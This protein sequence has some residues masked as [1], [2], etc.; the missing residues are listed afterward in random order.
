MSDHV[1]GAN[2]LENLTTG[3]YRDSK[4]LYREYIQN[5][6]D[7]ID[8]AEEIGILPKRDSS[9]KYPSIGQGCIN[10]WLNLDERRISIEDNGTGIK[11]NDFRRIL[12]NIA[13]SDKTLGKEKGFRGI[14]RLCG[15]A[16]CNKLVFTSRYKNEKIISIMTCDALKMR[17]MINDTNTKIKKYS[18][19]EVLNAITEFSIRDATSEDPVHFFKVELI[20]IN[21]ENEELFG[22]KDSNGIETLTDYLSFIAPVPYQANFVYRSEIYKYAKKLNVRIDEYDIR[23]NAQQIYKKYKTHLETGNG[24][25]D[26]FGVEFKDFRLSNDTLIAWMWFGKT[27]FKA[28]IKEGEKSRGIRLRKENIQIGDEDTLRG[29]FSRESSKRGN[30]YFVGEIFATSPELIPNSQRTYFNENPLR[31]NLEHMLSDYFNNTLYNIYYDG[32]DTSA[33][34]KK[35]ATYSEAY[36]NFEK[37]KKEGFVS[38]EERETEQQILEEKKIAA[39][40]AKTNLEKKC[41]EGGKSILG[42]EIAKRRI[43]EINTKHTDKAQQISIELPDIKKT[44]TGKKVNLTDTMFPKHNHAERKLLSEMLEK[45]FV[46]IRKT[47]DKKTAETI[48]NRIKTD[49]K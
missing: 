23:I 33:S 29:M 25:D 47:T 3:M 35:I 32:S 43:D 11:A 41:N 34:V 39:E 10:I 44:H 12:E 17:K 16:Y 9:G 21:E 26:V 40:K 22:G 6:C 42:R 24:Q 36:R 48:I 8:K 46:I 38:N 18:A 45:V 15:L 20:H 5:A 31:I 7:S 27:T 1:F 30:N 13:D 19:I 14:G 28:A 37:K 49:L 2:I 4:V